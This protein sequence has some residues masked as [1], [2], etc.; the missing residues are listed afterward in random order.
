MIEAV[1]GNGARRA[2]VICDHCGRNDTVPCGYMP[3]SSGGGPNVGQ[4]NKKM[5]SMGWAVRRGVLS[6]PSCAARRRAL[7]EDQADMNDN[8]AKKQP[9]PASP[10]Q[11][12]PRKPGFRMIGDICA[13]LDLVYDK[14][15]KGYSN[16]ADND[17]TVAEAIGKG[18]M[19]GWVARAREAEYGPDRRWAEI[20]AIRDELKAAYADMEARSGKVAS[21]LWAQVKEAS[22]IAAEENKKI[23]DDLCNRI[24][25]LQNRV[26]ALDPSIGPKAGRK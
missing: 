22:E 26:N 12:P 8:A 25:A 19:W 15:R 7:K 14:V 20:D 11:E 5:T 10:S 21:L 16:P 9:G 1:K 24:V 23:A 4:V 2:R 6:C 3:Q 17:R 13:M 18:C